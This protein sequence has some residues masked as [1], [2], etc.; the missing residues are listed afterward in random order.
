M[1][2]RGKT[3]KLICPP[4]LKNSCTRY[5]SESTSMKFIKPKLTQKGSYIICENHL[6]DNKESIVKTK[7]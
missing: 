1:M 6:Q 5:I 3:S 4:V 2:C 7:I